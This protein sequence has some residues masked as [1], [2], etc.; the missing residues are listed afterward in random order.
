MSAYLR[1]LAFAALV[2]AATRP[3]CAG[4][5]QPPPMPD[6]VIGALSRTA[7]G[8]RWVVAGGDGRYAIA[9]SGE[10]CDG[11]LIDI[12]VKPGVGYECS[13]TILGKRILLAHPGA[14]GGPELMSIARPGFTIEVALIDMGCRNW[15]GS[16]VYACAA[17]TGDLYMLSASGGGCRGTPPRFHEPVLEFLDGL[18][19][20]DP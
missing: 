6:L 1:G 9:C 7:D 16:P 8:G 2:F 19:L 12:D 5:A 11:H 3:A 15:T 20:A 4:E 17:I 10:D 18:V 14:F 13:D